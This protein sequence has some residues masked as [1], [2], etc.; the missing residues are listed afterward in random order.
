MCRMGWCK[1][2][3]RKQVWEFCSPQCEQTQSPCLRQEQTDTRVDQFCPE[4]ESSRALWTHHD[5]GND[6]SKEARRPRGSR[7]HPHGQGG[8]YWCPYLHVDGQRC[9]F[10]TTSR[11]YLT[12]HQKRV[13]HF[14]EQERKRLH[15][16][17]YIYEN[18]EKCSAAFKTKTGLKKHHQTDPHRS[19]YPED[20]PRRVAARRT[21]PPVTAAEENDDLPY[22]PPRGLPEYENFLQ[23]PHQIPSVEEP[24]AL[25][26]AL[27][28]RTSWLHQ[29]LNNDES[30]VLHKSIQRPDIVDREQSGIHN[31][32]Y[33]PAYD[34][35]LNR[36]PSQ[37]P[38]MHET[39]QD[40]SATPMQQHYEGQRNFTHLPT[41]LEST[42]YGGS[43]P[44]NPDVGLRDKG[45]EYL[46]QLYHKHEGYN[47][48]GPCAYNT[49]EVDFSFYLNESENQEIEDRYQS[50]QS[51]GHHSH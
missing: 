32:L 18:G 36:I 30:L 29:V 49:S 42:S 40:T 3:A 35:V 14:T 4:C 2:C 51:C 50:H 25:E 37:E 26:A 1:N 13:D 41:F 33:M 9:P 47:D 46:E 16:C 12:E 28:Q 45:E 7:R 19:P 22:E 23:V 21:R 8:P 27:G 31:A 24:S 34:Q 5:T 6:D 39:R 44:P 43:Y 11:N 38:V 17:P 10:S 48:L 20:T 15:Q